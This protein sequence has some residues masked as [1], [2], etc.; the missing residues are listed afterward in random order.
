[1]KMTK[2]THAMLFSALLPQ[3]EMEERQSLDWGEKFLD[4]SS[5]RQLRDEF[6]YQGS[7]VPLGLSELEVARYKHQVTRPQEW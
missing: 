3:L 4:R 6:E 1:M 5:R 2:I 7:N